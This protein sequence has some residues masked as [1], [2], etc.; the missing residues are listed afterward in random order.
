MLI[1]EALNSSLGSGDPSEITRVYGV[2][3]STLTVATKIG[4]EVKSYGY[5]LDIRSF[6]ESITIQ[7]GDST[8][9]R[10]WTIDIIENAYDDEGELVYHC[11]LG[12]NG[13]M[14]G[15]FRDMEETKPIDIGNNGGAS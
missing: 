13:D 7:S 10:T 8:T 5:T 12:S 14:L 15:I 11:K 1:E 4:E 3:T 2:G 6:V 9:T